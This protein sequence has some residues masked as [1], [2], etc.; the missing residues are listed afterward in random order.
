MLYVQQSLGPNEELVHIGKFHWMYTV[1]AF[2]S[3]FWGL[4]ISVMLLVGSVFIY[5]NM[6]KVPPTASVIEVIREL[7]PGIRALSF[8]AFVMGLLGFAQKMV[9]KATT[10]IAITNTR[11]VFKRG[12][13]ARQVGEMNIDRIEG[14]NVLQSVLGR[15]LNYG[16][17][18]VRG[19][20]IGE[21]VL[22]PIEDPVSFRK[23]IERAKAL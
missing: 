19:M 11:L 5:V 18:M 12:L 14:V 15:I 13:V 21:V 4:V 23:A 3:I 1:H 9:A 7:H 8:L 16:R 20:G 22:P 6:G 10:E 17:I 2:M